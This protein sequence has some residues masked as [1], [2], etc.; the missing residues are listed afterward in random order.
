ML[1]GVKSTL[2][3]GDYSARKGVHGVHNNCI[4]VW[5][6]TQQRCSEELIDQSCRRKRIRGKK[7]GV[8]EKAT[9]LYLATQHIVVSG[10]R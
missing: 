3:L 8:A 7:L 6:P 1:L 5:E 4:E 9:I 2:W 10:I